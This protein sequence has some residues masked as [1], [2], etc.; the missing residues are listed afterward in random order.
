MQQLETGAATH[1]FAGISYVPGKNEGDHAL[2][3]DASNEVAAKAN[4]EI[5][6]TVFR[7]LRNNQTTQKSMDA[8]FVVTRFG[9]RS[10]TQNINL[11]S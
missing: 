4:A 3:P 7:M 10:L 2:A 11:R 9:S 8:P 6:M 1:R 5:F